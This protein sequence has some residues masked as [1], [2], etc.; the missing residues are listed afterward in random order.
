[1]KSIFLFCFMFLCLFV[2]QPSVFATI[3][4]G[5]YKL[6]SEDECVRIPW[7]EYE[8]NWI[9]IGIALILIY[10]TMRLVKRI[11]RNK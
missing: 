9:L 8:W 6:N 3:C 10:I 11:K 2:Y 7:Y 1:M 5:G 4:I